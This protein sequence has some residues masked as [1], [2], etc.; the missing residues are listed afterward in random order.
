MKKNIKIK[1]ETFI[2]LIFTYSLSFIFYYFSSNPSDNSLV[3]YIIDFSLPV[4]Y[5]AVTENYL[6]LLSYTD[7][8][9]YSIKGIKIFIFYLFF[10][11]LIR[12]GNA[13]YNFFVSKNILSLYLSLKTESFAYSDANFLGLSIL[14]VSCLTFY[15]YSITK[16]KKIKKYFILLVFFGFCS[17][18]R[19]VMISFLAIFYLDILKK[20]LIK[21]KYALLIFLV[22]IL[23]FVLFNFYNLLLNDASFRSKISIF[24]GLKRM[25]SYNLNNK[26]LGFGYGKGEYAYSYIKDGFGHLHIA[27]ILG[28]IGILGLLLFSLWLIHLDINSLNKNFLI[29]FVSILSGFSLSFYDSSFFMICAIITVLENKRRKLLKQQRM[30]LCQNK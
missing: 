25:D 2:F 30:V 21:R 27:L 10:E 3:M 4:F 28:Q 11:W 5:Y 7:I 6:N 12:Y 20:C 23:P 24:E 1:T 14:F 9:K 29:I 19:S 26:L 22:I 16:Q 17:M 15:L 8:V 18:S 13:F